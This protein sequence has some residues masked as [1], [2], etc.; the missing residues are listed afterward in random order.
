MEPLRPSKQNR[1]NNFP[2]CGYNICSSASFPM[3]LLRLSACLMLGNLMKEIAA[4]AERLC[5]TAQNELMNIVTIFLG[6]SVGATATAKAFVT[7]ADHKNTLHGNSGLCVRLG[8]AGG[9]LL[10]KAYEPVYKGGQDKSAYRLCRRFRRSYGGARFA[11]GGSERKPLQ[12]PAYARHGSECCGRYRLCRCGRRSYFD[13]R[14]I[15]GFIIMEE[16]KVIYNRY[17]SP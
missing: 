12:L 7:L 8:T 2:D 10:G 14:L 3:R 13:F 4:F 6:I 11:D 1:K 16:K 5:K 17:H 9:V 15:G